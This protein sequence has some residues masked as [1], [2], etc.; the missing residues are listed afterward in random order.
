MTLSSAQIWR[1]F[2]YET[3]VCG[4]RSFEGCMAHTPRPYGE[5][6][7]SAAQTP[8][9][10]WPYYSLTQK[11]QLPQKVFSYFFINWIPFRAAVFF[12]YTS[13][14]ARY[15]VRSRGTIMCSNSLSKD[16]W[17]DNLLRYIIWSPRM[18]RMKT[19][20]VKLEEESDTWLKQKNWKGKKCQTRAN[21]YWG[22]NLIVFSNNRLS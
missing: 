1:W 22:P 17:R 10:H 7:S 16:Y 9:T 8:A 14:M 21:L 4:G 11:K 20:R 19:G 5:H 2:L 12:C 3:S 15:G 13:N 6:D 18:S